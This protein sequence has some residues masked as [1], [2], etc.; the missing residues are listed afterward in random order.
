MKN[1]VGDFVVVRPDL[2][3]R[4]TYRLDIDFAMML[5]AGRKARITS[6]DSDGDCK[7]C[8]DRGEW[9]WSSDMIIKV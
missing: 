5:Y 2:N 9:Y 7:L 1:K 6:I 4:A 3:M 8:I